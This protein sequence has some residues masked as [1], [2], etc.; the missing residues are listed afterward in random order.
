MAIAAGQIFQVNA[1][2]MVEPGKGFLMTGGA[3]FCLNLIPGLGTHRIVGFVAGAA[4]LGRD[5]FVVGTMT[6]GAGW[7]IAGVSGVA[8]CARHVDMATT[9][10]GGPPSL[11]DVLVAAQT[12]ISG[13]SK[14]REFKSRGLMR[15]MA[16]SAIREGV[17]SGVLR[18]VALGAAGRV[19]MGQVACVAVE[20]GVGI[21]CFSGGRR[22]VGMTGRTGLARIGQGRELEIERSVG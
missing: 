5:R 18:G 21:T 1:L 3:P 6:V 13:S 11:S 17:V 9:N 16:G 7:R 14:A 10:S 4:I 19:P 2:F 22:N 20:F 12:D 8:G 15:R